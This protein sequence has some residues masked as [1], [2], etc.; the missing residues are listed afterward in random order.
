[1]G[2]AADLEADVLVRN[3]ARESQQITKWI[4]DKAVGVA[5]QKACA[6]NSRVLEI[7]SI[8]WV[9]SSEQPRAI[10]VDPLRDE[11]GNTSQ[12]DFWNLRFVMCKYLFFSN[13]P[14]FKSHDIGYNGP[15]HSS[16]TGVAMEGI[17]GTAGRCTH[18]AH[19]CV[20][21]QAI[22][23]AS[24][25]KVVKRSIKTTRCLPCMCHKCFPFYF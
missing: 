2:L 23:L 16:L 5:S 9:S 18:S 20:G 19:G 13:H 14:P 24:S 17:N 12:L 22:V 25:P 8:W 10:P 21:N 7:V 1:M 4:S 6:L 11:A 3:R 15:N